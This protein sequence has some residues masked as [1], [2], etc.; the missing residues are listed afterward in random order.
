MQVARYEGTQLDGWASSR[1]DRR[2]KR[3]RVSVQVIS[4][5]SSS[6]WDG[7]DQCVRENFEMI[8]YSQNNV[9]IQVTRH[10]PPS[11]NTPTVFRERASPLERSSVKKKK[12]EERENQDEKGGMHLPLLIDAIMSGCASGKNPSEIIVIIFTTVTPP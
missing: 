1:S 6:Y 3:E 5:G 12:S 10:V 4:A 7:A 2:S 9:R 8:F 11:S